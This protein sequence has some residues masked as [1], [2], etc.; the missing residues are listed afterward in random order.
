MARKISRMPDAFVSEDG[1]Y[2]ELSFQDDSGETVTLGFQVAHFERCMA[3]AGQLVL[4]AQN[5]QNATPTTTGHLSIQATDLADATAGVPAGG[6]KVILSLRLLSGLVSHFAL[7]PQ[8]AN[9]LRKELQT[10]TRSA[11]RQSRSTR[12]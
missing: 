2:V 11:E 10:A 3:L 4:N 7:P 1:Q 5:P 12:H 8:M 9:R 6:S